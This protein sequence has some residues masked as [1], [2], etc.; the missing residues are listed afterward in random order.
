MLIQRVLNEGP[1]SMRQL[2]EQAGLSYDA[3][4]S[5]AA[6]RRTPRPDN[7]K[8]LAATL[9]TRGKHLSELASELD[10]AVEAEGDAE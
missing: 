1:F 7:L 2:A 6:D 10:A 4:R 8:Q 9:R 5:W 3:L